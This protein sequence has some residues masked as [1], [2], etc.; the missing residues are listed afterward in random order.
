MATFVTHLGKVCRGY[1][2]GVELL[3]KE[4]MKGKKRPGGKLARSVG[5]RRKADIALWPHSFH[6]TLQLIQ[7]GDLPVQ[8]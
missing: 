8:L 7:F 2:E 3:G 4:S 1:E 5:G 6:W